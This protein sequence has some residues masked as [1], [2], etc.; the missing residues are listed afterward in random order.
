MSSGAAS[1]SAADK[2]RAA[3][4]AASV[5]LRS[6]RGVAHQPLR[7]RCPLS[8][9]APPRPVLNSAGEDGQAA[10]DRA[11]WTTGGTPRGLTSFHGFGMKCERRCVWG[12]GMV[13]EGQLGLSNRAHMSAPQLTFGLLPGLA[14]SRRL[15]T[16]RRLAVVCCF[17]RVVSVCPSASRRS[18]PRG[19]QQSP[20]PD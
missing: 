2:R 10:V 8:G 7:R 1:S 19:L 14:A 15:W 16:V 9:F 6:G 20:S 4:G 13:G 17:G 18:R 12:C 11:G 3:R 5:L